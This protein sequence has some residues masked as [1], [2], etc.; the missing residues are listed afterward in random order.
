[1]IVNGGISNF[2]DVQEAL[3]FTNCDGVMSS[4][5]ILEYPPLFDNSQIYDLE[6]IAL[7]YLDFYEKY[8]GEAT[9]KIARCHMHKFLHSGFTLHGHTDLRMEINLG[10]SIED[11]RKTIKEMQ[12][13]REGISAI[14][15]ITWYYRYWNDE[16]GLHKEGRKQIENLPENHILDSEWNDWMNNDNRNPQS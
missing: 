3:K 13:R 14:D 9:I 5:S 11:F 12:K 2:D 16:T 7:E 15:K 6:K 1:M 4:E 8:P 10:K